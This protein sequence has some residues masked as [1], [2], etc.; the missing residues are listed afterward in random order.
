MA[1]ILLVDDNLEL[2]RLI[3]LYLSKDNSNSLVFTIQQSLK[4][5]NRRHFDLLI[6]DRVLP[7]GDGLDI[8]KFVR[9]KQL[10]VPVLILSNKNV[11]EERI[12]GLREGAD[13]YLG[14]PF[15]I[16]E[17]LLRVEKLIQSTKRIKQNEVRINKITLF[18]KEVK[19][20]IVKRKVQFR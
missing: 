8:L 13:D 17:L 16:D 9:D 19:F 1:K 4:L 7:D 6:L 18:E 12:T 11:V 14:K 2:S 15:S 20:L 5:L 10:L 3:N